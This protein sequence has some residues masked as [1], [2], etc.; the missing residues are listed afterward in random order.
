VIVGAPSAYAD[1]RVNAGAAYVVFGYRTPVVGYPPMLETN[2]GT[3]IAPLAPTVRR[4]GPARFALASPL[5]PGLALDPTTGVISGTP[6]AA[7]PPA[8]YRVT[9]TDLAG[10]ASASLLIIVRGST[11]PPPWAQATTLLPR[12]V[13]LRVSPRTFAVGSRGAVISYALR[14][15]ATVR[16]SI[17][18]RVAGRRLGERC[19]APRRALR[20]RPACTRWVSVGALRRPLAAPG[21]QAFRFSG[22]IAGRA[23][24]PGSYQ[25]TIVATD[26]R[27]DAGQPTTASFTIVR[28]R[29]R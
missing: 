19:V 4:T 10:S 21:P 6:T 23:L 27:G 5:P 8:R 29:K 25:A 11:A 26:A 12:V 15:P 17:S 3:P 13:G 2:V 20:H 7:A 16:V 1:G 18:H 24:K 28:P 9:M 22:R 14:M